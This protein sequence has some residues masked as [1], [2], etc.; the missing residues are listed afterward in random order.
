MIKEPRSSARASGRQILHPLIERSGSAPPPVLP[1]KLMK[2]PHYS[3]A[4]PDAPG[5]KIPTARTLR[6][7][8]LKHPGE[9]SFL[10][11]PVSH[12]R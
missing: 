2:T 6:P 3:Q 5:S 11:V 1:R 9:H 10:L 7:P 8:P 4:S 12:P